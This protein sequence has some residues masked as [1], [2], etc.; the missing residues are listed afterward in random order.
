MRMRNSAV[1]FLCALVLV[2]LS[3]PVFGKTAF[4]GSYNI[5]GTNPGVG[6]Y[7]GALSISARGEV[8]D[9]VWN[10]GGVSY[11][12]IGIANGDTL[13]VAYTG[14]DRTWFGVVTYKARPNGTLDGRW[15]VAGATPRLGTETAVRK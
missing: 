10:V 5:T 8:Y 6:A 14:G 13:S 15:A 12:G 4:S 7:R 11:S 9:V 1:L 3:V 2:A